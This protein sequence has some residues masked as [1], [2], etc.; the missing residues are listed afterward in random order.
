ML[1]LRDIDV[2]LNDGVL[3]MLYMQVKEMYY[4]RQDGSEECGCRNSGEMY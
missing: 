2:F 1:F 4:R 3:D